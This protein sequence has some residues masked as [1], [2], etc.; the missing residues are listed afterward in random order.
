M[1]VV[2]HLSDDLDSQ[3]AQPPFIGHPV[4][5]GR[6]P[7]PGEDLGVG[8]ERMSPFLAIVL[9][10]GIMLL[11]VGAQAGSGLGA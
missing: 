7:A 1:A 9:L 4:Y 10:Y 3:V 11:M 5:T 6:P 2:T 8:E